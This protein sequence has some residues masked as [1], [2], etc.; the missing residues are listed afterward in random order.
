MFILCIN[1]KQFLKKYVITLLNHD[2]YKMGTIFANSEK[3]KTDHPHRL[4][5][6]LI[7]K[8]DLGRAEKYI[9][10]SNLSFYYTWKTEKLILQ[11]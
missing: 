6:N 5:L 7:G 11:Q 4:L 8:I 1:K 9:A 10:L 3:T 2:K